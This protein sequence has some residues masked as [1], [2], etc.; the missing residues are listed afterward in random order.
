M[1][2]HVNLIHV[3]TRAC[4]AAHGL[5]RRAQS[6][7]GARRQNRPCSD[8]LK[9]SLKNLPNLTEE[10]SEKL[11]LTE[12]DREYSLYCLIGSHYEDLIFSSLYIKQRAI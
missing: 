7:D 9:L 4:K 12:V 5:N 3:R 10:W 1:L 6:L 2:H 8:N 11:E